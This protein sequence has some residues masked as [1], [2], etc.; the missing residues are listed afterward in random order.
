MYRRDFLVRTGIVVGAAAL[1]CALKNTQALLATE[2]KS[3]P[4]S[5]DEVRNTFNLAPNRIHMSAFY[6]SS[7]PK[8]V[9]DAIEEHRRAFDLDPVEYLHAN[10]EKCEAA[11]LA[12]AAYRLGVDPGE[13]ALTDSTTM[14]LGLLYS[15]LKLRPDQ[16]ILTT[17]HDHY[18]TETSLRLRAERTGASL[19]RISLYNDGESTSAEQIVENLS[20][21]V[22]PQTRVVAV[23]WVHSCT[24]V[25]LPIRSL[26]DALRSINSSRDEGDRLLLCVDGLH[27]LG[28]DA[29]TMPDLGCDFFIAG[30]HK[31]IFG[32]RGTGLVWG[33]AAAWKA[34]TATV[35]TFDM[36]T[37][38]QWMGVRPPKAVRV[39]PI[40][41]PGGFHSFE[42]RW[43][44][45][46]AFLWHEQ[47]GRQR[48]A[49][50]T[51]S[52]NRQLKEGLAK[53]SRVKLYTPMSDELSAGI[54]CF[55][56]DGLRADQVV[57]E[58]RKRNI[59]ATVTPY[60]THYTR[61]APSLVTS[62]Q[63][64]DATLAAVREIA[65]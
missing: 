30:T 55:D 59:V 63:E 17:T 21:A 49:D 11:V 53:M 31:W 43:A 7:H 44:L 2:A 51:H 12:A 25:K 37:Y 64:V 32:P 45:D 62:P 4:L 26:A 1:S 35:P 24:G 14:G 34:A 57:E 38:G 8:P 50:R 65:A 58:L 28:V 13:I 52:Q 3:P 18:S 40:M 42:H 27:G 48:I 9:R 54:V 15:G 23:T 33:T 10:R 6:L 41:T 19:R 56:V 5:W 36:E 46:K 60:K 20:R 22:R 16:E 39:G 29:V 61:L 47:V